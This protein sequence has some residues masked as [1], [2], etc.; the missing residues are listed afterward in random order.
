MAESTKVIELFYK[1]ERSTENYDDVR[2]AIQ[3]HISCNN[4]T[5]DQV[6]IM[7]ACIANEFIEDRS[8]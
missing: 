3:D 5:Q 4:L 6:E 8:T 1:P 2:F 7:I